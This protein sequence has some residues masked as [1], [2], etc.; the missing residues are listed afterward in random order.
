MARATTTTVTTNITPTKGPVLPRW[1]IGLIGAALLAIG[2]PS[3]VARMIEL[4]GESIREAIREGQTV[5]EDAMNV[6]DASHRSV[7]FWRPG[8]AMASDKALINLERGTRAKGPAARAFFVEAEK[9]QREALALAPSDPYG[10]F[11]LAYLYYVVDGGPSARVAE[12][13]SQSMAAAPYEPRM[14]IARLQMGMANEP[15]LSPEA[16]D[17][18]PR[19]IRGSAI[20]DAEGLARIAKAGAFT[21]AVEA[22]LINDEAALAAFRDRIADK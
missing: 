22:A 16:K 3:Y 12:A 6:L 15:F 5:S 20:F 21:A 18:L 13:W 2:V 9:W 4:P 7:P 17:H 14:M 8:S 19:L 10:W 11:R 1:W